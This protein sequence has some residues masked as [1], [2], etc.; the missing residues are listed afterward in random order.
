MRYHTAQGQSALD[1]LQGTASLPGGSGLW[2]SYN[3]LP[4]CLGKMGSGS[5][6]MHCDAAWEQG[7]VELVQ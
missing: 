4:Y 2:N 5:L 3:A 1:L 7:T 6:A